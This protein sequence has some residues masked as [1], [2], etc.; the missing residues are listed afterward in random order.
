MVLVVL[1]FEVEALDVRKLPVVEFK[2]V[3]L[4]VI[5]LVVV[6]LDVLA[7]EVMKFDVLPKSVPMIAEVML[8]I[9]EKRF[10]EEAVVANRLV[11][12]ELV[13]VALVDVRLVKSAVTALIKGV[14]I[15]VKVALEEVEL[16]EASTRKF[17]FSIQFVPFHLKVELV[18]VPEAIDPP[19]PAVSIPQEN[20]PVAALYMTLSPAVLQV[21]S[22]APTNLLIV[23][24]PF[25][26]GLLN[27]AMEEVAMRPLIV[28]VIRL[29]V[30]E[31][32]ILEPVMIV[33]VAITPFTLEVS[34]FP[35]ED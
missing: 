13:R 22:P 33:V 35:E 2:V 7:L 12:V 29:V 19:L 4:P 8:A 1:A 30:V 27:S 6:A 20:S 14:Y 34:I 26:V 31:K 10:V 15:L 32:D 3:I 23:V 9:D 17:V 25:K 11:E 28:L 5:A 16:P 21:V 24:V 18:A